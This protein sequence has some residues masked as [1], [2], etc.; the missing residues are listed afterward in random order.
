LRRVSVLLAVLL[1]SACVRPL[2]E[3]PPS[4]VPLPVPDDVESVIFLIGD[5]GYA[6]HGRD[7]VLRRLAADV[8]YWSASLARDTA[9][10][11]LFLGD[12]VYPSGVRP[13]GSPEYPRDSAIVHD[14]VSLLAGPW[15]RRYSA[16]GYF[17]AGNHDWGEARSTE[18]VRRLQNLEAFLDRRREE[19]VAVWLQPEAGQ[20]GPSVI[21][22]GRRL[23]LLLF[24]TAWWML[25]DSDYL[26]RRAFQQTEDAIRSAGGRDVVV[27]AHHPFTSA[28][29]HGGAIPIRK[30]LGLRYLMNRAGAVLQDLNSMPYRELRTGL[31]RAFEAGAP[32]LFVGGHDHNLQVMV[33]DTAPYP[34]YH[35]VSGSGSKVTA[36]G[37]M[38]GMLYRHAAPGFAWVAVHRSGR[39][40][41]FV[42]AAPD[43]SYLRCEGEGDALEQCMV[44]RAGGFQPRFGMRLR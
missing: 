10:A 27:A 29:S 17:L 21:D 39:V 13:P 28:S 40:D 31:L 26:K 8:E 22:V 18:G 14:Q 5:A 7:P 16:V 4:M 3:L 37:H 30:L 12:I 11:V 38:E 6:D 34:R 9:V 42:T 24:D 15:A 43:R 32:L 19:G 33:G 36:V 23:R 2:P 35:V 44:E 1:V 25:A 41:L 20:P